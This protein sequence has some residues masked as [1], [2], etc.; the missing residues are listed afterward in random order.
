MDL[1]VPVTAPAAGK[2][3]A[4]VTVEAVTPALRTSIPVVLWVSRHPP[5]SGEPT[6]AL[7]LREV[8]LGQ[9]AA[10]IA[11]QAHCEV[12]VAEALAEAVVDADF[13]QPL[14]VGVVLELLAE[15][16]G[17]RVERT[18]SGFRLVEAGKDAGP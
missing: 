8:P 10:T 5:A 3:E 18:A 16:V 14:P 4:V 13:S 6:V 17:G 2:M 11:H 15:Q 7:A 1:T 12:E 9:A